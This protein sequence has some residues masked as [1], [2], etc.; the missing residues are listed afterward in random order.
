[1]KRKRKPTKQ[2]TTLIIEMRTQFT[3]RQIAKKLNISRLAV[4]NILQDINKQ[5]II[6]T[7]I[8]P[9]TIE[10]YSTEIPNI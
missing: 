6:G 10:P 1:M 4:K 5:S 2:E 8:N 7:N 9:I 3:V